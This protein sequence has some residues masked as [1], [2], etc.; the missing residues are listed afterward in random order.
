MTERVGL[1]MPQRPCFG[2]SGH[3]G[4]ALGLAVLVALLLGGCAASDSVFGPDEVAESDRVTL[5]TL[6]ENDENPRL[7]IGEQTA[8]VAAYTTYAASYQSGGVT[9]TVG[10]SIPTADG[11]HP[12][13][14]LAHGLTHPDSF[15]QGGRMNPERDYFARAGYVVLNV[16]L[17]SSHPGT[18]AET[19]LS[20]D[21]GATLDVINAVRALARAELP[22]QPD[23]PGASDDLD[24]D[25]IALLGHSM[26]GA[27]VINA[28]VA[29]PGLI[30]AVVA[31][32]PASSD[33]VDNVH[34]LSLMAG[35]TSGSIFARYGTPED[36]PAFWQD[37]SARTF[38]NRAE[39]PL[40][41]IHGTDD[42]VTPIEWSE[43]TA[44]VWNAT[45]SDVRLEH[46]EGE[47]HI[48]SLRW[49]DAMRLAEEFLDAELD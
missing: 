38:A 25:R 5:R 14:V 41:I 6:A 36:Q 29:Q 40:L 20:I 43:A 35:A 4:G 28:M 32:A 22:G 27:L 49:R 3:L 30:D 16:D 17:R 26:G 37:I 39:A 15:T 18:K 7:D 19:A 45:G 12:G 47:G 23:L 21:M 13:I 8:E 33:A 1:G 34:V 46:L 31:I 10:L 44:D 24:E 9:I 11:P 2:T 48:L 42:P